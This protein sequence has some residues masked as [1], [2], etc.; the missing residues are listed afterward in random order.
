[1]FLAAGLLLV[2]IAVE[3][4]ATAMLPKAEG[5]TDPGWTAFVLGGYAL[6]IW[7]LTLIVRELPVSVTYAVWSG[8]GTAAIA[9]IGVLFLHES[10]DAFKIAGISLVIAGVVLLNLHAAS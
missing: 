3:V 9:V 8:L 10:V 7:L 5:F 2:A 1:M 4:V 6:S